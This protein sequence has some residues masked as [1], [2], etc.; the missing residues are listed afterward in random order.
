[1]SDEFPL[2]SLLM[3]RRRAR[4]DAERSL[5]D[6]MKQRK[7]AQHELDTC[8]DRRAQLNAQL[9]A[10]RR[11]ELPD[12]VAELQRRADY[13]RAITVDIEEAEAAISARVEKLESHDEVVR[14]SRESLA[15]AES[16]LS[17]V[18]ERR[19]S[20]LAERENARRRKGED[21]MDEVVI[22]SWQEGKRDG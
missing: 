16:E 13:E 17:I 12:D 2:A 6:A 21:E 10:S 3:V 19:D 8:L 20:W 22:R 18:E 5:V 15:A 1:M 7:A 11:A 4:D 9:V 14:V